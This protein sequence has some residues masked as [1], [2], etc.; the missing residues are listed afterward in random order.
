[1]DTLAKGQPTAAVRY[2]AGQAYTQAVTGYDDGY[3]PTS[4]AVTI[5]ASEGGLAD[6]YTS[7]YAYNL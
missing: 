5:P 3:R 2:S 7:L 1:Y 6:T 4:S